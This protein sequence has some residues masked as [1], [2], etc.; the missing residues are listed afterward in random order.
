MVV[1]SIRPSER[2][3]PPIKWAGGKG[4]LISQFEPLFPGNGYPLYIEPFVG[5][6]AVFFHLLPAEAILID[7]NPELVNF[8]RVLKG[9]VDALVADMR[10][11]R[12]DADYF[13]RIRAVNTESLDE[14]AR[15]S[16]FLYLNKTAYNGLYRVNRKGEFNVPFGRY[17][18]PRIVDEENLRLVSAA[19]GRAEIILGDFGQA[20][21]YAAPGAFVYLDPPYDPLSSTSRFTSYTSGSF[22]EADQLRLARVFRELDRAGCL[23]MLSNSD[24]PFIRRL[25]AGY[26]A[27]VVPARRA[28]NCRAD[29]RGP[30]SELVIRNYA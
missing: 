8:Y 18:N 23:L 10:K 13:Y 4:G 16:R 14:V 26:D 22:G 7:D 15:A 29:R 27:T 20:L 5:G 21:D 28:I 9:S 17:R 24:T 30:V 1:G 11:H 6:G 12:S 2:P 19:L 25:Y 3:R